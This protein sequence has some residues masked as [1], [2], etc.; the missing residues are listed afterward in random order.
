MRLKFSA[1][2]GSIMALK[3]NLSARKYTFETRNPFWILLA[4]GD[5]LQSQVIERP[6]TSITKKSGDIGNSY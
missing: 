6:G 3:C 5:D 1:E 2:K 4:N